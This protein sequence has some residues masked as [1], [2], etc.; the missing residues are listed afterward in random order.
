MKKLIKKYLKNNSAELLHDIRV[1]ARR[2]LAKLQERGVID[3]GLKEL[4]NKSSKL[5]DVDVMLEICN[6]KKIE[7]RLKEER[8]K[9]LKKFLKFLRGFKSRVVGFEK[10]RCDKKEF[11]NTL[12]ESFLG[13]DDKTLHKIRLLVKRC[14]YTNRELEDKLKILQTYLGKAHDY[15]NCEKLLKKHNLNTKK[16]VKKKKKYIE[17]AEKVRKNLID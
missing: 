11:F 6:N 1:L 10:I 17:K 15:Y 9:R 7:K 2:E 3:L 12:S 4:L 5:R 13:K 16:A 8:K 14:R